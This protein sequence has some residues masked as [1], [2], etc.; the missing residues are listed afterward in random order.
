MC[1]SA[2]FSSPMV[3]HITHQ[4][5]SVA[6]LL[7]EVDESRRHN[8]PISE[9]EVRSLIGLVDETVLPNASKCVGWSHIVN[10]DHIRVSRASD[11]ISALSRTLTTYMVN[12]VPPQI[13]Y[14]CINQ[15]EERKRFDTALARFE[16]AQTVGRG[17]DVVVSEVRA[18]MGVANREF[19]EWRRSTICENRAST[20]YVTLFRSCGDSQCPSEYPL[21]GK[22]VQRGETW[23]SGYLFRWWLNENHEPVGA[24]MF[25][26]SQVDPKGNV[27]KQLPAAMIIQQAKKWIA[28]L[29][30]HAKTVC[31]R[32][33]VDCC[34]SD[35]E[36]E[37][38]LSLERY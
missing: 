22:K 36:L 24:Q 11:H 27:P 37:S 30:A 16:V 7:H 31:A 32:M 21:R 4:F 15:P 28:Q 14:Y 1:Y 2:V 17:L 35:A 18:P 9:Q 3:R 12:G 19:V 6:D 20:T 26:L 5:R 34:T 13:L 8:T 25:I 29:T 33:G 38:K 23:L 10:S